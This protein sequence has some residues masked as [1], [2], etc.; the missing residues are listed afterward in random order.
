MVR[1]F[2]HGFI[3]Q[4]STSSSSQSY[5]N[6]ISI[7]SSARKRARLHDGGFDLGYISNSSMMKNNIS[8]FR[9]YPMN[10]IFQAILS[11]KTKTR[12]EMRCHPYSTIRAY[13]PLDKC[14]GFYA[15]SAVKSVETK[16]PPA[17]NVCCS[18]D[19]PSE[20][21]VTTG[22]LTETGKVEVR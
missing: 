6:V 2:A 16:K 4:E 14:R 8:I 5:R 21:Y 22:A 15:R 9:D 7:P 20:V 13:I 3:L 18:K 12:D 19:D 11:Y 10:L 17:K 1:S